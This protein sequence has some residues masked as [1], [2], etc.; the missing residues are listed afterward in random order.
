MHDSLFRSIFP[1]GRALGNR[2]GLNLRPQQLSIFAFP[3]R[4]PPCVPSNWGGGTRP[5]W[6]NMFGM[7]V[8]SKQVHTPLLQRLK[9]Q[10]IRFVL[11][12]HR[13]RDKRA[14][15]YRTAI[16][17]S[18]V[19]YRM[20]SQRLKSPPVKTVKLWRSAGWCSWPAA[21][22]FLIRICSQS[23]QSHSPISRYHES[24]LP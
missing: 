19:K 17:E 20:S 5:W 14:K 9:N 22:G 12:Q 2:E 1:L 24:E 15:S 3:P 16:K 10:D 6:F 23:P 21:A 7:R 13:H 8:H 18:G 4:F 11:A